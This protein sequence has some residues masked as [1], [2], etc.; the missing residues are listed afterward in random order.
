MPFKSD[1][2]RRFMYAKHPR[3][4]KR[5][6]KETPKGKD[7]PEK[8]KK[9]GLLFDGRYDFL[10]ALMLRSTEKV[11]SCKVPPQYLSKQN[12]PK[13]KKAM[14]VKDAGI[15]ELA[16]RAQVDGLFDSALS[17]ATVTR[18]VKTRESKPERRRVETSMSLAKKVAEMGMEAPPQPMQ[19]PMDMSGAGEERRRQ[20][21]HEQQL[22]FAEDK[23]NLDLVRMQMDLEQQQSR[24]ELEQEHTQQDAQQRLQDA[25]MKQQLAQQKSQEQAKQQMQ[26]KVQQQE[27]VKQ[28]QQAVDAQKAMEYRG[29]IMKAANVKYDIYGEP[30]VPTS[31]VEPVLLGTGLGGIAAHSLF[32]DSEAGKLR[33]MA[34]EMSSESGKGVLQHVKYID[35]WNKKYNFKAPENVAKKFYQNKALQANARRLLAGLGVGAAAG[36]GLHRYLNQE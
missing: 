7:L 17:R 27:Q 35:P 14:I 33:G 34:R 23:H 9:A 4:A 31:P 11:A 28:Q 15:E 36:Y 24:F 16:K 12:T 22:Q 5:W 20:E 25:V 21:I 1:A 10:D 3:I 18:P 8:V 19:A 6:Q 2:Q 26:D 32:P 13:K 30:I 29:N